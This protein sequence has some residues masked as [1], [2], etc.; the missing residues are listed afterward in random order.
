MQKPT[1]IERDV[2]R[3]Q[4]IDAVPRILTAVTEITGMRFAAVARVTETDWTACSV[5]DELGFGLKPG[6]GL[7]VDTTIC[8]E[9]RH[10]REPVVFGNASEHPVFSKHHTPR[11]YGLQ[12]YASV[13]IFRSN[14]DFFGTLCAIDS[15]PAELDAPGILRSL[16]LFAELIGTQLE[17]VED[18]DNARSHLQDAHAREQL[19]SHTEREVRDLLQPVVTTLFLLQSS[20]TLADE[21]RLLLADMDASCKEVTRVLRE[22]LVHALGGR[23]SGD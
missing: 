23:S 10:H 5:L 1:T 18:L 3:I 16:E 11:L 6:G 2:A 15:R 4:R 22:K 21:D 8:N 13:P 14:G 17:L 20:P 9:I 7:Q 19:L 12:S